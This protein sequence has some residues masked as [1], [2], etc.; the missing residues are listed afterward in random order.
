MDDRLRAVISG[1]F[2]GV[3]ALAVGNLDGLMLGRN[4]HWGFTVG[5]GLVSLVAAFALTLL[6][7]K[8]EE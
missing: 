6:I 2:A 5:V 8:G 4:L 1:V 7:W 3:A